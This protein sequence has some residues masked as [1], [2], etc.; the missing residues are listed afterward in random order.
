MRKQKQAVGQGGL[1][2]RSCSFVAGHVNAHF[3]W[4]SG[5]LVS[6]LAVKVQTTKHLA[7]TTVHSNHSKNDLGKFPNLKAQEV[8][9][10]DILTTPAL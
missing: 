4:K 1:E 2:P 3:Q 6:L 5:V 9:L 10:H 8:L 7:V